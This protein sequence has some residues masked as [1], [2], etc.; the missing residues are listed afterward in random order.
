MR[1]G[2][3]EGN[4]EGREDYHQG[5]TEDVRALLVPVESECFW[6][7]AQTVKFRK[8]NLGGR[9]H[10]L[11]RRLNH[12]SYGCDQMLSLARHSL[13]MQVIF[14][15]R[16]QIGRVTTRC[17]ARRRSERHGGERHPLGRNGLQRLTQKGP[18]MLWNPDV[19][20]TINR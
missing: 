7:G 3:I 13:F 16:R 10:V 14:R 18:R 20:A 4:P 2:A 6:L 15:Q 8:R 19:E 17:W 5:Q 11:G 12:A 1:T 9:I